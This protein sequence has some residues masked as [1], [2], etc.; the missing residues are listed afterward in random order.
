MKRFVSLFMFALFVFS[1]ATTG[2]VRDDRSA[3]GL[4][5]TP[6]DFQGAEEATTTPVLPDATGYYRLPFDGPLF[7]MGAMTSDIAYRYR[8][9]DGISQCALFVDD[10]ITEYF[11][12]QLF[13][14][15]FPD[16]LKS[17]NDTFLDWIDNPALI[18]LS[19][20]DFTIPE[21]QELADAGYLVL[22]AYYF[23]DIAGHVAFVGHSS[24]SLFTYPPID[25]LEGKRGTQMDDTFFPV[26][27]QAGTYTGVTSMVF[28]T[29]G[30]LR[31]DNF[32]NGTVRYYAV[33]SDL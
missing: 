20:D 22:M 27:V 28:A 10:V 5:D 18:R 4:S 32:G 1:C 13:S 15:I 2:T 30:W 8:A 26:M 6:G 17:A 14:Q 19:P 3:P 31:D 21:I 11:G 24:L 25:S 29:N 12:D 7:W 33:K 23:P 16:G 9:I